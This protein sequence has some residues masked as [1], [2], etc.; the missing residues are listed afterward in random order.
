MSLKLSGDRKFEIEYTTTDNKENIILYKIQGIGGE[1]VSCEKNGS[2]I[3]ITGV[4]NIETTI[5]IGD[6]EISKNNISDLSEGDTYILNV[7]DN[8]FRRTEKIENNNVNAKVKV[9]KIKLLGVSKKISEGKKIVLKTVISP[10]NASN[11]TIVWKSSNPKVATVT[12][13]GIVTMKKKTGGK[14]VAI[15]AIAT[16]GS[17]KYASWKITSMKGVVKKVKINGKK[18]IKAG[19]TLKLKAKILATKHANKKLLWKSNN[20]KLATVNQKGVVFYVL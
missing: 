1:E 16:D 3:D 4:K 13:S 11:K 19:K 12:Q 17:N 18:R 10:N 8:T 20:S 14:K 5:S 15:T 2:E 9:G 7:N 6:K